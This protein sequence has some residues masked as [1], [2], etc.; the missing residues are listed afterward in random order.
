MHII[1]LLIRGSNVGTEEF[2]EFADNYFWSLYN[3]NQ[4]VNEER[5]F[6]TILD[7]LSVNLFCP[8]RDSYKTENSAKYANQWREKLEIELGC[9]FEFK[10]IGIDPEY[11]EYSIPENSSFLILKVGEFSSV[12]DGDLLE[13]IP[14]YKIPS[15]YH[16]GEGYYNIN[17]WEKNFIRVNGLWFNGLGEGFMQNQLEQHDSELNKKGIECSKRIEELTNLPTYYFLFNYNEG[18]EENDKL[19][20]C[21][22]CGGEWLIEGK[23]Y[24]DLY[25]F[26][27]DPCRLICERSSN[28]E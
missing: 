13:P 16:D 8:E 12:L 19:K 17:S 15:T 14:L 22:G 6:E 21:P 23:T 1:K 7:G 20:K 4:I 25:G 24:D 3:C 28:S 9:I 11:G 2:F 27:C 18:G 26:K 10:Y 5:Q